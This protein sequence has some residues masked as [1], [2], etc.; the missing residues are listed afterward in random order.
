MENQ[1]QLC[2]FHHTLT[3]YSYSW[4]KLMWSPFYHLISEISQFFSTISHA[5]GITMATVHTYWYQLLDHWSPFSVAYALMSTL[6][7]SIR[8]WNNEFSSHLCKFHNTLHR[9]SYDEQMKLL[10]LVVGHKLI[11]NVGIQNS[12]SKTFQPTLVERK[13]N[14]FNQLTQWTPYDQSAVF[15]LFTFTIFNFV[16]TI[17]FTHFIDTV[18]SLGWVNVVWT[19]IVESFHGFDLEVCDLCVMCV[20]VRDLSLEESSLYSNS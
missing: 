8:M 18:I 1:K 15:L 5:Y 10:F 6:A 7:F 4:L 12:K 3:H 16:Y 9:N 20:C 11:Q 17:V 19:T 14:E 13:L 2:Q